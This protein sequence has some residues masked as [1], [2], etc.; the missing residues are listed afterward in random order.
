MFVP[1]I[2]SWV[3]PTAPM[4]E[5]PRSAD[6]YVAT[7]AQARTMAEAIGVTGEYSSFWQVGRS[8]GDTPLSL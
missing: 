4:R 2:P 1:N 5:L 6:A 8:D 3:I 7:N